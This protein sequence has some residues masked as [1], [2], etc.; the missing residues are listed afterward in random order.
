MVSTDN[1]RA[2]S[3]YAALVIAYGLLMGAATD[4][5][6]AQSVEQFYKGRQMT[7]IVGTAPGGI[8]DITARFVARHLGRYIPGYHHVSEAHLKRHLAGFDFRYNNRMSAFV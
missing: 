4:P 5:A 6:H 1:K 3:N 2:L 7:M 8:N